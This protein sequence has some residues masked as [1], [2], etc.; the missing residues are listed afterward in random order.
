VQAHGPETLIACVAQR[1]NTT[2]GGT[3]GS[4]STTSMSFIGVSA[5]V[6][7]ARAAAKVV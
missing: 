1:G 6:T 7:V 3:V 5:G 4:S 2:E